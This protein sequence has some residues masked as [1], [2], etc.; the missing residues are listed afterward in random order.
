MALNMQEY[1]AAFNRS[2]STP[3]PRR[4]L[5]ATRSTTR[6]TTVATETSASQSEAT[7][8]ATS[9]SQ[10]PP[11]VAKLQPP[12]AELLKAAKSVEKDLLEKEAKLGEGFERLKSER[13]KSLEDIESMK[14]VEQSRSAMERGR[15]QLEREQHETRLAWERREFAD[16]KRAYEQMK[17][18]AVEIARGQ[19]PIT[20]EVGGEKF[21]TEIC[22]L[23][24]HTESIFP[25]LATIAQGHTPPRKSRSDHIFIDRDGKHFRF[26]LNYLR[27][28]RE[29]LRGTTL[30][31]TDDSF[32]HELLCEVRY[33]KLDELERLLQLRRVA[34][35]K[36][37]DF[38]SLLAQKLLAPLK[39]PQVLTISPQSTISLKYCTTQ[40]LLFKQK[41]LTGVKFENVLFEHSVSF[42]G[43]VLDKATFTQCYFKAAINFQ[44]ADLHKVTFD[45]CQGIYPAV[46]FR[47]EDDD[48]ASVTFHPALQ[49]AS[50]P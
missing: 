43:S 32:L 13:V 39:Q 20:L 11:S 18:N 4:V 50:S 45:H 17:A 16:E 25:E 35:E 38:N 5:E 29:V 6:P 27:Q 47:M 22:T 40:D 24:K 3:E 19:D 7:A 10:L 42:E 26:I 9:K 44:G 31:N 48:L 33:Y 37:I 23:H 12:M 28:G 15:L 49:V 1:N 30:R 36:P 2:A 34:M 14:V 8:A 21:R 41:N 46:N